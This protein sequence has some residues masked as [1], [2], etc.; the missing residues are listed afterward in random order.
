MSHIFSLEGHGESLWLHNHAGGSTGLKNNLPVV[1]Y[2]RN[3]QNQTQLFK[4]G[5]SSTI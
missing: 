2:Y 3:K 4:S 1:I 5:T